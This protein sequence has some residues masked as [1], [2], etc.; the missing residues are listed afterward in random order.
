MVY[1]PLWKILVSWDYYAQCMEPKKCEPPTSINI[2]QDITLSYESNHEFPRLLLLC[3]YLH[4]KSPLGGPPCN[5]LG[6]KHH[7]HHHQQQQLSSI[8]QVFIPIKSWCWNPFFPTNKS[9]LTPQ[10]C[11]AAPER[12]KS[13]RCLLIGKV[14]GAGRKAP[15]LGPRK[16]K[17]ENP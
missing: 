8:Y 13:T 1:L 2:N 9:S 7:H 10:R 3:S 16:T 5:I 11:S 12:P 14:S 4:Q 6:E 17:G 15:G